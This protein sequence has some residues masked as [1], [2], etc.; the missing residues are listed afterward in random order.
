MDAAGK[1]FKR[2]DKA[3]RGH[4]DKWTQSYVDLVKFKTFTSKVYFKPQTRK[5]KSSLEAIEFST[6]MKNEQHALYIDRK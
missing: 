4:G 1:V 5:S 3:E 6:E 2:V